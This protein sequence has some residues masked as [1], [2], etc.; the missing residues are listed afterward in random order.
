M[1]QDP[2]RV[3][4]H[5][6]SF[7]VDVNEFVGVIIADLMQ[8]PPEMISSRDEIIKALQRYAASASNVMGES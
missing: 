8:Q 6:D 1:D 4:R 7:F 5:E 2:I 3:L